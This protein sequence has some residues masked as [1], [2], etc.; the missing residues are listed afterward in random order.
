MAERRKK[1]TRLTVSL[2]E[3]DCAGVSAMASGSDV[4]LSWIVRQAVQRFVRGHETRPE[5]P[6]TL[7]EQ[8]ERKE[9]SDRDARS[10]PDRGDGP[11]G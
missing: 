10:E 1:T 8:P 11:G 9:V 6:P 7:A 5:L 2:D 3:A 4:S